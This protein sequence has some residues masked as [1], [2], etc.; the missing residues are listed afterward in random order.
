MTKSL[1]DVLTRAESW[2]EWAQDNLADIALEMDREVQSGTYRA[3]E[4]E[5]RKIDEALAAVRR[6]EIATDAEVEAV[7]AKHRGA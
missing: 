5:L 3:T 2:P 6:G 4:E 1:K 7:F